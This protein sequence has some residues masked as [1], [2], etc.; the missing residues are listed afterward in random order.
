MV[1]VITPG[2]VEEAPTAFPY[3]RD[4]RCTHCGAI[5]RVEPG[6]HGRP[7]HPGGFVLH[8]GGAT[9]TIHVRCPTPRCGRLLVV[10]EDPEAAAPPA[11]AAGGAEQPGAA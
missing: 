8:H 10:A 7:D 4:L 5:F 6:D 3:D 2:R 9:A 1:R 11:P